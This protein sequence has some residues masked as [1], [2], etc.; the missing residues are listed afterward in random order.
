[1]SFPALL[2][3][4]ALPFETLDFH[5][6]A[7][8]LPPPGRIHPHAAQKASSPTKGQYGPK[9]FR[10]GVHL[11]ADRD[12]EHGTRQEERPM[13]QPFAAQMIAPARQF[14]AIIVDAPRRG[15]TGTR[16]AR[17]A[18]ADPGNGTA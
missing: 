9:P 3:G 13:P 6:K 18:G 14:A 17:R 2:S 16:E 8:R 10:P 5:L 12:G 4:R 1:M 15:R 7:G 11:P